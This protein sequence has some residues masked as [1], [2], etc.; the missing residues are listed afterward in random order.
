[1]RE[2]WSSRL[3]GNPRDF[4]SAWKLARAEYWLGTQ[5]PARTRRAARTRH[6]ART[7]AQA[8][9]SR[10]D[11]KA[12]SGWPRTWAHSRNRIGLRQ[13]I[14]YRGPIKDALEKVLAIDPAFQKGSAD[15]ALGRGTS[16]CQGCLVAARRNPNSTF[17]NR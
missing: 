8:R 12:T 10:R 15:R 5:G 14:K 6:R 11:P 13:G 1:V 9:S 17:G 7:H 3:A 2:I 4:E 16:K